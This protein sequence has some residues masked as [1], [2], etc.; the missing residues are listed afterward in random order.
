MCEAVETSSEKEELSSEERAFLLLYSNLGLQ[1]LSSNEREKTVQNIEVC[2][3][4]IWGQCVL[5]EGG[6]SSESSFNSCQLMKGS[7]PFRTG[8]EGVS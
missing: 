2:T 5:R 3:T 7:C 8:T 4:I 1:L 6:S